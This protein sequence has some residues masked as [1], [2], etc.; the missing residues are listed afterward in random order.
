MR[1]WHSAQVLSTVVGTTCRNSMWLGAAYQDGTCEVWDQISSEA[2][3]RDPDSDDEGVSFPLKAQWQLPKRP[4]IKQAN[5][6]ADVMLV[7]IDSQETGSQVHELMR[8][9]QDYF[10]QLEIAK[11]TVPANK[12]DLCTAE[13]KHTPVNTRVAGGHERPE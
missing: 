6:R 4:T 9:V 10:T 12:V 3:A 7:R 13:A 11:K 5:N 1:A 8:Q 2:A